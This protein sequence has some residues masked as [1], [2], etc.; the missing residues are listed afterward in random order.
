MTA[1]ILSQ[2]PMIALD[3]TAFVFAMVAAE[4]SYAGTRYSRVHLHDPV[5]VIHDRRPSDDEL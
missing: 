2:W 4:F 1:R 3:T 5:V